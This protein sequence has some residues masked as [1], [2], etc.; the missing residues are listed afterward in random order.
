MA[1]LHAPTMDRRQI[2]ERR[3]ALRQSGGAVMTALDYLAM[4]LLIV[5]GLNWAMVALFNIDVVATVFGAGSAATRLVYLVIGAC[6]LYSI[7]LAA[8]LGSTRRRAA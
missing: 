4:V 3:A 8:K 6:A 2:P 5:G 7:Y 1:T